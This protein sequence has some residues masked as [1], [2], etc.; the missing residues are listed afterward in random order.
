METVVNIVSRVVNSYVVKQA[1]M[2][3]EMKVV[4]DTENYADSFLLEPCTCVLEW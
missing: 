1:M 3:F 4:K 2:L